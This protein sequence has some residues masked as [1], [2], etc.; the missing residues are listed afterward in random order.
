MKNL[1]IILTLTILF[2]IFTYNTASAEIVTDGLVSYWTFDKGDMINRTLKDVWGENNAT[3]HG[4][5]KSVQGKVGEAFKFDGVN[6]YID[7]TTLEDF[8]EQLGKSTFEA[9]IKTTNKKNWMT[10]VNTNGHK[11][12][13][14]SIHIN[15]DRR[16]HNDLIEIEKG[17][18]Y[19][20]TSLRSIDGRSCGGATRGT[21]MSIFDGEWHHIVYTLHYVIKPTGGSGGRIVYHDGVK[22]ATATH[23]F[24][25]NRAFFPFTAPVHLGARKTNGVSSSFFEGYIDEVRIYNRPLTEDQVKQNYASREPFNVEPKGKLATLW[26][27]LKR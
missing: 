17:M 18:V 24:G 12:P 2:P 1:I 21:S 4:N 9:W 25:G 8:G 11:C 6:D 20:S 26:G 7:L 3:I 10:L 22:G 27:K 13:N 14:W 16:R 15:G 19:F 23:S 5:P